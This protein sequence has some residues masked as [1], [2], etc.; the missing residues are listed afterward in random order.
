MQTLHHK[1]IQTT[2]HA[3]VA[4]IVSF[5]LLNSWAELLNLDYQHKAWKY[6]P[7]QHVYLIPSVNVLTNEMELFIM[8]VYPI[9]QPLC[10]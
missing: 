8:S 9:L 1:H 5:I 7:L 6:A 2:E 10:W 4:Y 3:C